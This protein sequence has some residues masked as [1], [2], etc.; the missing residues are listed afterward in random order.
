MKK[1]NNWYIGGVPS[2]KEIDP[3]QAPELRRTVMSLYGDIE[4][5]PD[6]KD[7]DHIQC[8]T[9]ESVKKENDNLIVTTV[10][11]SIYEMGEPNA[12]YEKMFPGSKERLFKQFNQENP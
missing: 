9:I 1:L 5:H 11:G 6:F 7:G 12:D 10:S 4:N 8:S 2:N 3:F